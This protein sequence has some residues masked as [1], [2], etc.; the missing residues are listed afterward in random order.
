MTDTGPTTLVP[1]LPSAAPLRSEARPWQRNTSTQLLSALALAVPMA[2]IAWWVHL[3]QEGGITLRLMFLGPM[4]GGGALTVWI[5]FLHLAVCGDGLDRLGFV[6][7]SPWRGILLGVGLAAAL[8]A[9]HFAFNAAAGQLFPPRRPSPGIVELIAGV[10]RD[11]W[12]LALWLGPVVW[13]G[14]AFFEELAR[15]FLLRRLWQVW[16]GTEGAWGAILAVSALIGTVHQ[17]QGS[18]AVVSIGLQSVLLC[19]FYLRTG[20]I[21]SLIVGHAL[22]DSAQIVLAV[23]TIRQMGL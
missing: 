9:F 15:A 2:G 23:V 21:L 17:Y 22:Y 6:R 18:G 16:P 13:L 11:P 19:W 3:L 4:A 1:L 12:L 5:L 8:L 10:A 14:V 20:S 7:K